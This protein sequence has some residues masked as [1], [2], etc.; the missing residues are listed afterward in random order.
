MK[1]Y[2]KTLQIE[3]LALLV[4]VLASTAYFWREINW[5]HYIAFIAAIDL[6]G[7]IPGRLWSIAFK[8]ERPPAIFYWIYNICH[9]M[10]VLVLFSAAYWNFVAKD[11]ALLAL[12]GHLCVDRGVLGNFP[13]LLK[14]DFKTPT[15]ELVV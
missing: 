9:N 14:D 7:Y 8:T 6:I 5:I 4:I 1:K 12:F 2:L 15:T 13:K 11:Y 10:F 3:P